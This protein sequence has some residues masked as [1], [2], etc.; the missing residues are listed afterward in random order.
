MCVVGGWEDEYK[1]LNARY[2]NMSGGRDRCSI[3]SLM[4][5]VDEL[6]WSSTDWRR[7]RIEITGAACQ[8]GARCTPAL[9]VRDR[10]LVV[11]SRRDVD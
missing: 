6:R 11:P 10:H 4:L 1:M 7:V 3:A 2:S 8:A 5:G 9:Y